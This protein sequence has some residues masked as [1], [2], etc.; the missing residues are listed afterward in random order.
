MVLPE[1]VEYNRYVASQKELKGL[2]CA[3]WE[4]TAAIFVASQKELK[5][6][7]HEALRSYYNVGSIPKGIE[8]PSC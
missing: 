7:E 4:I 6:S 2:F 3:S 1:P 5:D 8:S